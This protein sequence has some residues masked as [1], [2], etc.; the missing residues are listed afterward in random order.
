MNI[1]LIDD[2]ETILNV[3]SAFL[4]DCGYTVCCAHNGAA[5]LKKLETTPNIDLII[6]DIRMPKING[7]DFLR[8]VQVRYPHLPTILIT[9]HGDEKIAT[10]AFYNGAY[11]YLKKP[12]SLKNLHNSVERLQK[13]KHF[14]YQYHA[15]STTTTEI[16]EAFHNI[17]ESIQQLSS[18]CAAPHINNKQTQQLIDQINE[19][20]LE[21]QNTLQ[22]PTS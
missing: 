4:E 11:D 6:S 7:I 17:S 19:N 22:A 9:G 1:M 16:S 21:L 12:I 15:P 5:A 2:E 20:L 8:A 10:D 13:Q 3:L 18:I 14:E